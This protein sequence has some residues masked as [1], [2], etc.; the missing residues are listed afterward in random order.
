MMKSLRFG[1]HKIMFILPL[2]KMA[3]TSTSKNLA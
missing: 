2:V 1:L 3:D